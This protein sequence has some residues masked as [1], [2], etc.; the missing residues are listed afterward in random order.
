MIESDNRKIFMCSAL[1]T[2]HTVTV[3]QLAQGTWVYSKQVPLRKEMFLSIISTRRKPV[4]IA[5]WNLCFTMGGHFERQQWTHIIRTCHHC[6]IHIVEIELQEWFS[7]LCL[8]GCR[9]L[10]ALCCRRRRRWKCSLRTEMCNL[11][12]RRR[13]MWSVS[14][15]KQNWCFQFTHRK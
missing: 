6:N 10:L 12:E 15:W 14:R 11:G 9:C 8:E 2:V 3:D 4:D 7:Y 1:Y 13:P 5:Q